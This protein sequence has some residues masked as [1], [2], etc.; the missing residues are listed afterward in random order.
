MSNLSKAMVLYFIGYIFSGVGAFY[1][2]TGIIAGQNQDAVIGA[3]SLVIG[4]SSFVYSLIY[5]SQKL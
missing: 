2:G 5:A 3:I 1:F 4:I